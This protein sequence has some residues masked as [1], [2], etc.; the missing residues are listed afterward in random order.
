M[1]KIVLFLFLSH[2]FCHAQND[3]IWMSKF[4]SLTT[5][6]TAEY[7]R[8]IKKIDQKTI[9]I[10]EY[11][12]DKSKILEQLCNLNE[13]KTFN[14]QATQ[15]FEDGKTAVIYEIKNNAING[16]VTSFLKN[17]SKTECT[18][19]NNML[20]DGTIIFEDNG[21]Y[22]QHIAK[23]GLPVVNKYYNLGKENS[24]YIETFIDGIKTRKSFD[25]NGKIIAEAIYNKDD[26]VVSG[27]L[28]EHN[29]TT[30]VLQKLTHYKNKEITKEITLLKNG[31]IREIETY[32]L[33]NQS[34]VTETFDNNG[35]KVGSFTSTSGTKNLQEKMY[36]YESSTNKA[37]PKSLDT[38]KSGNLLQSIVFNEKGIKKCLI[39]F[40]EHGTAKY[41]EYY[42]TYG[43]I[44]SK[45]I[46]TKPGI[47]K[48]GLLIED[49]KVI[50]YKEGKITSDKEFYKSGEIFSDRKDDSTRFY[51]KNGN[52]IGEIIYNNETPYE[53][54]DYS[55]YLNIDAFF[56]YMKY[57][58][59]VVVEEVSYFFDNHLKYVIKEQKFY[60]DKL[61]DSESS[62]TNKGISINKVQNFENGNKKFEYTDYKGYPDG[63]FYKIIS[64]DSLGKKIGEFDKN[65]N[66]GTQCFY[67]DQ[68]S[69]DLQSIETYKNGKLQYEKRFHQTKNFF[70]NIVT[71]IELFEEIIHF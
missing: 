13:D 34:R 10:N 64:F 21:I 42:D 24:G 7:F 35:V 4:H 41:R 6:Q 22:A 36:S 70:G 62:Y 45:L 5:K 44:T 43:K 31:T 59:G 2:L 33:T 39:D 69:D 18:Y 52:Q 16:K 53:G 55:Y 8:I 15:F 17:G 60:K 49:N 37:I 58:K 68:E 27:I 25:K 56:G 46:Y 47:P 51:D 29:G 12:L 1:K 63:E 19:K 48:E 32:N 67:Y 71:K 54:T 11:R 57:T 40:D 30:L 66:E 65:K 23:N 61:F 9:Q 26:E 38:Y 14:G 28:G 3:T 20:F 50:E